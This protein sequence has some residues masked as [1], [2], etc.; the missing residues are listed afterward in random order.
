MVPVGVEPTR[1]VYQTE[2][3]TRENGTGCDD[4]SAK[5]VFVCCHYTK[6]HH[7]LPPRESNPHHDVMSV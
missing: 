1:S 3:P 4:R 2:P 7:W 5:D 6:G